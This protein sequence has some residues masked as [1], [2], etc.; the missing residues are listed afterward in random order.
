[1]GMNPARNA[2]DI[3]MLVGDIAASLAFYEGVLG[4]K[5]VQEMR[6]SFGT[7]HRMAFGDSFIKLI[8]P[9]KVPPAGTPGLERALGLR[10]LTFPVTNIDEVCEACRNAGVRFDVEKK[11]F[12]PGVTIAMVRDPDGNVVEFV[13]RA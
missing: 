4:L 6:V 9:T 13:Q 7:M 11:E 8:D 5:K 2:V 10:Y 12:M 1:M 3:G